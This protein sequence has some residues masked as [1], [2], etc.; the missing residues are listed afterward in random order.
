MVLT[1]QELL[2]Q[3]DYLKKEND[4]LGDA[5][6]EADEEISQL[7]IDLFETRRKLAEIEGAQVVYYYFLC[8]YRKDSLP[9][10]LFC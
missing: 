4:R 10:N 1:F 5:C 6:D 9:R 7:K 8:F 3:M 2:E